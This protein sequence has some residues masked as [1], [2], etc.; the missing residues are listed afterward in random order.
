MPALARI[1]RRGACDVFG[2]GIGG[3]V[4]VPLVHRFE[5]TLSVIEVE[6]TDGS[7]RNIRCGRSATA[8]KREVSRREIEMNYEING[9]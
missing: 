7:W 5:V 3:F 2:R 8:W 9:Q 6:D 4:F 1:G